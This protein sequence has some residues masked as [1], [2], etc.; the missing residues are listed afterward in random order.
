MFWYWWRSKI[1]PT[2]WTVWRWISSVVWINV[3]QLT[4]ATVEIEY[5][6]QQAVCHIYGVLCTVPHW[7]LLCLCVCVFHVSY[8]EESLN[9]FFQSLP[10]IRGMCRDVACRQNMDTFCQWKFAW[11]FVR[12]CELKVSRLKKTCHFLKCVFDV[13][14][15]NICRLAF[16]WLFWWMIKKVWTTKHVSKTVHGKRP[17]IVICEAWADK[18]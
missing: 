8:Q 13:R 10:C 6:K 3:L 5:D 17:Y 16:R 9:I 1:W 12:A 4:T 7:L 11:L 2:N 15:W 14:I 18:V